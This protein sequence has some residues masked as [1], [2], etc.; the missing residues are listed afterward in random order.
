MDVV[1]DTSALV[2]KPYI[3]NQ[4]K[5]AHIYLPLVVLEELDKLKTE[6]TPVAVKARQVIRLLDQLREFG[7]LHE[8]VSLS[9][10]NTTV[11]AV[12]VDD[13]LV[14]G[15]PNNSQ[16]I[17]TVVY[18]NQNRDVLLASDDLAMRVRA[19]SLGIKTLS[20]LDL[21]GDEFLDGEIVDFYY[22]GHVVDLLFAQGYLSDAISDE[23]DSL[24]PNQ[25]IN[26][27]SC[28]NPSQS[29]LTRFDGQRYRLE[30]IQGRRSFWGIKAK[31]REQLCAL[32]ALGD[33]DI[34][35]V[36][37]TGP[38]GTGKTLLTLAAAFDQTLQ[39]NMFKRI[40][41]TR[42]VVPIGRDLGFLPGSKEEKMI[43]WLEG[44]TDNAEFL[45]GSRDAFGMYADQG[46]IEIESITYMRGR[47]L[48]GSFIIIDEAQNASPEMIKTILTRVGK[49][50]KIV[51][52]GDTTQIDNS[53]L[54]ENSNGLRY[55]I[56]RAK[57]TV[58]VAHIHL[59]D[60]SIR[61][62]VAAWAVQNL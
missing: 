34:P 9:K 40:L 56:E 24:I 41:V 47:S 54:D 14:Y 10:T 43:V 7:K 21:C 6:K 18:L 58:L 48:Q 15:L 4:L 29:A 11:M 60:C 50:S 30:L 39:E 8:G 23:W 22:P 32:D 57:E 5:D 20:S 52:L 3:V 19:E 45:L 51:I 33:S 35:V 28:E 49:N 55:L 12:E 53:R 13:S 59:A 44:I 36:I 37:L 46:K 62:E 42:P 25:Y 27:H 26:I 61:S 1:L 38:S 2:N 16:I 31:N 17:K